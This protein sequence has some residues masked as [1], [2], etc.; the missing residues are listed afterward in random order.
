MKQ[1]KEVIQAC[2]EMAQ[3]LKNSRQEETE[4][5]LS[6]LANTKCRDTESLGLTDWMT[7]C[8][9]LQEGGR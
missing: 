4:S 7:C 5:L 1:E 9:L 2:Q 8:R 6:L 3:D